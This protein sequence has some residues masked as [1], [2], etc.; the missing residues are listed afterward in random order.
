[1]KIT[2]SI[3]GK[4]CIAVL[5][6]IVGTNIKRAGLLTGIET[7]A[8]ELHIVLNH[9]GLAAPVRETPRGIEPY[10]RLGTLATLGGNDNHT[11]GC[12]RTV[13][14]SSR[15]ILE[16]VD[17]SDIIG[18]DLADTTVRDNAVHDEQ[19][20]VVSLFGSRGVNRDNVLTTQGHRTRVITAGAVRRVVVQ[21][22]N[23]ARQG[24]QGVRVRQVGNLAVVE[25]HAGDGT[26]HVLTLGS[27]VT[28]YHHLLQVGG[29]IVQCHGDARSCGVH[30]LLL[31]AEAAHTQAGTRLNTQLEGAVHIGDGGVLGAYLLDGSTDD[32]L[33]LGVHYGTADCLLVLLYSKSLASVQVVAFAGRRAQRGQGQHRGS[34]QISPLL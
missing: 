15:G 34:E 30:G 3:I 6:Y 32:G 14:G 31:K 19:R 18:V 2:I 13:D 5:P 26:R 21:T 22:G 20:G 4:V 10:R 16:H 27:T 8:E 29:I 23:L 28:H 11:I 17:G 1:M 33:T 25:L 7:V 9:L 24:R 12:T